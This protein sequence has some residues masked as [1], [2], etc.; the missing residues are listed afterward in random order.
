MGTGWRTKRGEAVMGIKSLI[1]SRR[2][3]IP[4]PVAWRSGRGLVVG[5]DGDVW[6]WRAFDPASLMWEG[7]EV[8]ARHASK[9][10]N[11]LT[12]LGRTGRE[13]ML[14][15]T[16]IG[17]DWREIHMIALNWTDWAEPPEGTPEP[18]EE[19]LRNVLTFSVGRGLW[20]VGV[21]LR[22]GLKGGGES[23]SP[24]KLVRSF[25]S[26]A[27][28][29]PPELSP[30]LTD[31]AT[32][33]AILNRAGG[34]VPTDNELRR[35]E[36]W[37][38]GGD[39]QAPD[40][41]HAL[42]DGR[43]IANDYW[44]SGTLQISALAGYE[45]AV[46]D[47]RLW[48]AE[49]FAHEFSGC[50]AAS[51]RGQLVPPKAVR[52]QMRRAQR[53]AIGRFEEQAQTGDLERAEDRELYEMAQSMEETFRVSSAPLFRELSIIMAHEPNPS[54]TENYRDALSATS[55]LVIKP[56][57]ERQIQALM[58]MLPCGRR[59]IGTIKPFVHDCS[60]EVLS[61]C[62]F[63][64]FSQVGDESGIFIGLAPPDLP[65]VWLN[66]RG[67]SQSD[68]PA[69][70]AVLGDSGSGKTFLLQSIATQSVLEGRA[71]VVINPKPA[72]SLDGFC[73]AVGGT[74]V[75]IATAEGTA[76]GQ[77]DPFRFSS[78]DRAAEILSAHVSGV[79]S[80]ALSHQE[81]I[82]MEAAF[83]QAA[84]TGARCA[85][86]CLAS[87]DCPP[88]ARDLVNAQVAGSALF[89]L[90]ISYEPAPPLDPTASGLTLIEFDR[91]IPLPA[92]AERMSD[93]EPAV[94]AAVAALRLVVQSA[95]ES[96]F[97]SKEADGTPAG[98]VLIIDEAHALMGSADGRSIIERLGREGRSQQVLPIL[99]T[100]R[101][102]DVTKEGADLA[103]Y[104]S[105]VI[106]LKLS[107]R[108]EAAAALE[109][110]GLEPTEEKIQRLAE[111]GPIRGVRPALGYHRDLKGRCSMI[112]VGPLPEEIARLFSTNPLD[113]A[114]RKKES[115]IV[116][117]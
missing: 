114:A 84:A 8:R 63:G 108:D 18:L 113:R 111:A 56:V 73:E 104:L 69:T 105:R 34:R 97:T 75:K 33:S 15:G 89:A 6:L 62:G 42:P 67:A 115:A 14:K 98:G 85:G 74:N 54:A 58:E 20:A 32:V 107:D 87:T 10:S 43:S 92:R 96:M 30:Y 29:G 51:I 61:G 36:Q 19:W 41:L 117:E 46:M 88:N 100:Q 72:D 39:D 27:M 66:T 57:E 23:L 24:M 59:T 9:F 44:P 77:L 91:A 22:R 50:V 70:M 52:D 90:G 47:D 109:L 1:G 101:V 31:Q 5:H 7:L 78:P 13:P 94:R 17:S 35:L 71:V 99:A 103:S 21:K 68:K 116:N 11:M 64:S 2:Q 112:T 37:W 12:E 3:A 86:D 25:V 28:A 102:L 53:K 106:T 48:L 4:T 95:M 45:N 110:L 26:D 65:L 82:L 93:Y 80:D 55:G 49:A 83:K 60:I 79:M 81:R 16:R 40:S 76:P 38:K